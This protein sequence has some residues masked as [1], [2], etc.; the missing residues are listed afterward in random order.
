MDTM[1]TTIP[2]DLIFEDQIGARSWLFDHNAF[3]PD[4]TLYAQGWL[5][6]TRTYHSSHLMTEGGVDR[7]AET[8]LGFHGSVLLADWLGRADWRWGEGTWHPYPIAPMML[9]DKVLFY[10]HNLAPE[11]FTTNKATLAWNMAFGYMLSYDIGKTNFGG[12]ISDPWMSLV[13]TFQKEVLSRYAGDRM[14]S[15]S[16][17]KG[18]ATR[19]LFEHATVITNW[20]SDTSYSTGYYVIPP[21]GAMVTSNDI[22]A[23]VFTSYGGKPLQNGEHYFIEKHSNNEITI[24][25]PMG[26]DTALTIRIAPL[27]MKVSDYV[28]E[29]FDQSG[30]LIENIDGS[31]LN[32]DVTFEFNNQIANTTVAYYKITGNYEISQGSHIFLPLLQK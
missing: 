15:Y 20:S 1:T 28:I 16:S 5:A 32:N 4:L 19:S 6:H 30:V 2:S 8:E 3:S 23:G 29:A 31:I 17:L 27:W 22:T 18:A 12:G 25:Q 21:Y 14:V 9:R 7:L 10:Q 13:G 24:Q 11:T 26:A